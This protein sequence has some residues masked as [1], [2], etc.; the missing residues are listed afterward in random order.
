MGIELNLVT[1]HTGTGHVTSN[2]YGRMQAAIC[3]WNK[4]FLLYPSKAD[5]IVQYQRT[6]ERSSVTINSFD[7]MIQGRMVRYVQAQ[8]SLPFQ[9]LAVG[10]Y[11]CDVYYIRIEKDINSGIER[12]TLESVQGAVADT[13]YGAVSNQGVPPYKNNSILED[14]NGDYTVVDTPIVAVVWNNDGEAVGAVNVLAEIDKMPSI[15][16]IILDKIYPVGSLYMAVNNVSP[17]VLFGGTWAKI[18]EGRF[19]MS[20]SAVAGAK[21]GN[22]SITL[23][24]DQM[25]EHMH[26]M[27]HGHTTPATTIQSEEHSHEITINNG[28]ADNSKLS[29]IYGYA[30][31]GTGSA[32]FMYGGSEVNAVRDAGHSHSGSATSERVTI[33][34]PRLVTDGISTSNTGPKGAGSPIDITP[35]YLTVHMWHRTA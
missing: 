25:P 12:A 13:I 11:R 32:L 34:I 21:G 9:T 33:N 19:L 7:V 18:E 28:S 22:N 2:D 23:T 17:A 31:G 6:A 20:A 15:D 35:K 26:S 3:G 5:D 29:T 14:E 8:E 16:S 1:G 10:C 4:S 24:E 30:T 27:G